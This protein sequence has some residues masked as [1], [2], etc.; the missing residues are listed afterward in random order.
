MFNLLISKRASNALKKLPFKH[1]DAI[2]LA[3]EEIVEN[4]YLGKPLSRELSDKLS[5]RVGIYRI[6]YKVNKKDNKILILRVR[7]RPKV[8]N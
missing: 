4:L 1:Q 3:F 5:F 7:H 8:Y 2:V 6:I